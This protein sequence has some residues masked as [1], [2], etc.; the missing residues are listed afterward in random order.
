MPD[1]LPEPIESQWAPDLSQPL[2]NPRAYKTAAGEFGVQRF[3]LTDGPRSGTE[4]LVVETDRVRAALCPTRGLSLWKAYI[5]STPVGWNS[6]VQGPI[7]PS[8]VP[9]AEQS[10]L[11]WLD[12][13]D[14]LLVRCGARSFGAPDFDAQGNLLFGLHGR[15]GNLPA[16]NLQ[17]V[18]DEAHSLLVV[19]AEIHETRFLQY[20]LRLQV[21]YAFALGEPVI[22]VRDRLTNASDTPTT[23][24]MLYHINVGDPILGKGARMHLPNP[25]IVARNEHAASDLADWAVYR[26]PTAGY[27]EQVYFSAAKAVDDGWAEAL[28]ESA[29][30]ETAFSVR[31]K[32]ETLPFFTQWKNTVG[33]NDGYVTGLE[34]GTGFPNPRSFEEEKSRLVQLEPGQEIAFDLQL[35]LLSGKAL[36]SD[37]VQAVHDA[38]SET[39]LAS[40]DAN[41]CVPR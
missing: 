26:E 22:D 33:A 35:G 16:R 40:F 14:E 19:Q 15:V 21:Q 24:Q 23:A 13:F 1:P 18:V 34:P 27:E 6:P 28:L 38:T 9:L 17:V 25:L 41:W 11:G 10:G 32:P 29:D 37:A 20:N 30:G 4:L 3:L 8:L 36:V 7:H 39:K 31:Y 5:D 12:G 2:E